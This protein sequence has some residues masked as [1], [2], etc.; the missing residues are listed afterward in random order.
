MKITKSHAA[1]MMLAA[2]LLSAPLLAQDSPSQGGAA[3]AAPA[4]PR[5]AGRRGRVFLGGTISSVGVD[6]FVVQRP[7]GTPLTV[8]VD[9]QTRFSDQGKAIQLEDLKTGDHVMVGARPSE[10][11]SG[12]QGGTAA[13]PASPGVTAAWVRVVPAGAMT[14]FSGERAFGRIKAI[15]GNRL[16][17]ESR[18]GE[19]VIVVSSGAVIRKNSQAATLQDLKVGDRIFAIGKESNGQFLATR[20]MEGMFRRGSGASPSGEA[21]P[22]NR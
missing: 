5:Y 13:A 21:P 9:D 22:P 17:L 10:G 1:V 12:S 20:V 2:M 19:K 16:T 15:D 11:E 6:Q 3:Q 18:Q 4:G 8:Q 7:D 14:A